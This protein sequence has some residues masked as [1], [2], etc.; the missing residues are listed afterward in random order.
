LKAQIDVPVTK[1]TLSEGDMSILSNR[2]SRYTTFSL[3]KNVLLEKLR[4]NGYCAFRLN[5]D[6]E[7]DWIIDITTNDMRASDY[8]FSYISESGFFYPDVYIPNT[9]KGKTSDGKIVR[10]TIDDD[11]FW[12]VI[13]D[14]KK[15]LVIRPTKDYTGNKADNSFILYDKSDVITQNDP[16]DLIN[17][18]LIAP[19]FADNLSDSNI[20]HS[21]TLCTYYLKVAT[22]ADYEF[23][24]NR[25]GNVT[26]T[27]SYVF[28]AL[29][30]IE[31]V[32][33]S[34]FDLRFIVTFQNVW[35]TSNDPYSSTD[36]NTLLNQ[37]RTEWNAN[38]TSVSRNIAH[39]FTGKTLDSD[40]WGIAWMGHISD[41]YSYS[42]S[43]DRTDMFETTAHEIGHNLNAEHPTVS[44]CLCGTATAS[45]MCQGQKDNN[46]WFCQQSIGEISPFL[47]S[48][49]SYL[50][51]D[52]PD[53]LTL[54]GTVIGFNERQ[55]KTQITSTQVINSGFTIYKSPT[56]LLSP[57][58]EVKSGAVFTATPLTDCN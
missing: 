43:M 51:G 42:L 38:R 46:L 15:Q 36:A 44:S 17:D 18:A 47:V 35:T 39:L 27:Y 6:G 49:S 40:T 4:H 20:L 28:S 12:G 32:Y 7:H 13:L 33:E 19:D 58:F 53:N 31:G 14:S 30:L 57:G 11:E 16:S 26:A 8:K 2:M 54:S 55:A 50:T 3:D 21:A 34:T 48:H 22:D 37:F 56:I 1:T 41:S 10:L 9:Y 52:I 23:Y 45:V 5:I 25:G 24:Q 29:N